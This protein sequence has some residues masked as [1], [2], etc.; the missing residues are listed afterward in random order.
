M[1]SQLFVDQISNAAGTGPVTLPN[2]WSSTLAS[3]SNLVQNL[4]LLTSVSSNAMTVSLV[5]NDGASAPTSTAP[6]VVAFRNT[7]LASSGFSVLSATS[8]TS[9]TI[10][11]SATL[12][13][14]SGVNQYFY[15]YAIN[16][17][18]SLVLGVSAFVF[19]EGVLQSTTAIS[20]SATSST[21]LYSAS[22]LTSVPIRLIGRIGVNEATAGTW[23]TNAAQITTHPFL[24]T[25]TSGIQQVGL[26]VTRSGTATWTT[27]RAVGIQYCQQGG[28]WRL[29]FNFDGGFS[30]SAE[31]TSTITVT[32]TGVTFN[33]GYSGSNSLGGQSACAGFG[34]TATQF[35]RANENAN[36]LSTFLTSSF[37]LVGNGLAI[38]GD[39]ELASKP[40]IAEF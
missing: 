11:S 36:T 17:S 19:D 12:G 10:P 24:N 38:S 3:S 2:G 28:S 21:V 33:A 9:L 7:T 35:C 25:A 22:T 40:T 27:N 32:M 29:R 37:S 39:V 18:G 31:S 34:G 30:G 1:A 16:S 13:L 20:S 5:Q 14:A 4:G 26:T 15:V 23:L 6:V 8:T